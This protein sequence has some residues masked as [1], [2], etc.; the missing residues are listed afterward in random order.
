M[1][2]VPGLS[3]YRTHAAMNSG[4]KA[5]PTGSSLSHLRT[6]A[7]KLRL[8]HSASAIQTTRQKRYK[9]TGTK[10]MADGESNTE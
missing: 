2:L 4:Q 5:F 7:A 1:P 10:F 8:R 9:I 3:A 6:N